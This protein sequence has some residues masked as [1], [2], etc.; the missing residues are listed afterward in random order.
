MTLGGDREA[1]LPPLP[2]AVLRRIVRNCPSVGVLRQA[3]CPRYAGTRGLKN[4]ARH[5]PTNHPH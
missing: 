4:I 5:S 2:A 1:G 3:G